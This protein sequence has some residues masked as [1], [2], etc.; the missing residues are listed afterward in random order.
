M[1]FRV[2]ESSTLGVV[3]NLVALL[4]FVTSL[5]VNLEKI[6]KTPGVSSVEVLKPTRYLNFQS[7]NAINTW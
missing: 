7:E 6:P 3:G 4:F 5:C 2:V 1:S